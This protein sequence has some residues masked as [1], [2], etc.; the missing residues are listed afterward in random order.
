MIKVEVGKSNLSVKEYILGIVLI[1][2]LGVEY[3]LTTNNESHFRLAYNDKYIL[4]ND[5][6]LNEEFTETSWLNKK[7]LPSQPLK[8]WD[9]QEVDLEVTLTNNKLPVIYGDP[10]VSIDKNKID[11]GIDIFGSSF[12][13]LSRYEEAVKNDRDVHDRF[14]AKA[15]LAYQEGFLL[16]PI[17]NEYVEILW[18]CINYLWPEI[19]RK[20]RE[21]RTLVSCD[22]DNIWDRTSNSFLYFIKKLGGDIIKKRSL[23]K[24]L[25]SIQTYINVGVLGKKEKDP[26]NTF[27]FSMDIC[28]E[29]GIKQSFYFIPDHPTSK[30]DGYYDIKG[31]E[32]RALLKKINARG[33]EIGIHLSYNTY[34]D[35]KQAKNEIKV[36]KSV[37]KEEGITQII[38]GG[39]QH[40]LR[41]NSFETP[42]IWD[43][44]GVDYDSSL[45]YADHVGFRSGVCYEYPLYDLKNL[46]RLSIIE[47]PLIVMEATA[48]EDKYMGLSAKE[49]YNIIVKLKNMCKNFNGDF[50]LLWHNSYFTDESYFSFFKEVIEN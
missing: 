28:E 27:D 12:F 25:N 4:I 40:Y 26:F 24:A 17:V 11:I 41:W 20:H 33:H 39:R 13:M 43:E 19:K 22:V 5:I 6:F 8:I 29:N 9:A 45:S 16:R 10:Y 23:S 44:L 36:L 34:Q 50:T 1:D 47:R 38:K 3:E 42:L 15:S 32:A 14:P 35:L 48:L 46:K 30:I 31:K 7:S 49:G 21:F 37:L 18:S 2:F